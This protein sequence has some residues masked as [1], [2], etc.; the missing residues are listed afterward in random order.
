MASELPD[1][2]SPWGYMFVLGLSF[3]NLLYHRWTLSGMLSCKDT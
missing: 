3:P 2:L 1:E